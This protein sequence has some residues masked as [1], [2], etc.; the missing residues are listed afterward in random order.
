MIKGSL[1]QEPL[2]ILVT[3]YSGSNKAINL[4]KDKEA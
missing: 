3:L 2:T 4:I 1:I